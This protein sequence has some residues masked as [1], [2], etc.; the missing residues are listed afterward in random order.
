MDSRVMR[1]GRGGGAVI[2]Q[3]NTKNEFVKMDKRITASGRRRAAEGRKAVMRLLQAWIATG[4]F[5]I[6]TGL[7]I[8]GFALAPRGEI[9]QSVLIAFGEAMSVGC[10]MLGIDYHFN[11]AARH[12]KD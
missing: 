5:V 8:A 7:L 9:H 6:G 12:E 1:R 2:L 11:S 4:L 10:L 3:R